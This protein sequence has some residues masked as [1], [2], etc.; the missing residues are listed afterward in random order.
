M[1]YGMN[2]LLWT[3]ELND[4]VLPILTELKK[5]GYDGVE[6]PLFYTTTL[7]A[8]LW[9]QRLNE[10]GLGRTA[11]TVV[12]ADTNLI[13][14][15]E[16]IRLAGISHLK[17]VIDACAELEVKTLCGPYHSALGVFTGKGPTGD[18]MKWAADSL[19]EVAHHAQ[20]RGVHLAVEA[21]NRFECYLVNS[22]EQLRTLIRAV[23]HPHC[24]GMYD[25]F[26]ANFEEKN[27]TRAIETIGTLLR[28]VHI[29]E[30]DRSTPGAG[31]I[32]WDDTFAALRRANYDGW[33]TIEAFGLSLPAIAAATKIW[34][35]MFNS[36]ID[37]AKNGLRFMREQTAK[38]CN[39]RRQAP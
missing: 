30:N 9:K 3:A 27:M 12:G 7:K 2:L 4:E 19:R 28:H 6:I 38:Y 16:N 35:K 14:P 25:T 11:V 22:M 15:N 8:G 33:L 18:E 34:R 10:L 29:S 24:R 39:I 5:I 37:L 21:L 17:R 26:H 20:E 1:K 31:G 36:E 23:D 32:R 13:S